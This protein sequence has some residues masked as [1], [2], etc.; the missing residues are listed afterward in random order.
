ME[1]LEL[2]I[3][4]MFGY[5]QL[6][7]NK[8]IK[9]KNMK[10]LQLLTLTLFLS[11]T[12]AINAQDASNDATWEET[13]AFI[14]ENLKYAV[15]ESLEQKIRKED[16]DKK[17][18]TISNK[19]THSVQESFLKT[20]YSFKRM[21]DN[22]TSNTYIETPLNK[23]KTVTI[24]EETNDNLTTF[25]ITLIL[26]GKFSSIKI[27]D[28]E[29]KFRDKAYLNFDDKTLAKRMTTAFQHLAYLAK[30]KRKQNKF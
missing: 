21:S 4:E 29:E 18:A 16:L 8:I 12:T 10:T 9:I 20:H 19:P 30:E 24:K 23:L 6:G 26:T 22:S 13:T 7:G 5:Q 25:R 14:S 15:L 3:L 17:Y 27:Q 28:Y 11:I 1:G 2:E